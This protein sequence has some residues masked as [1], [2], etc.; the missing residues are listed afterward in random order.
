[1]TDDQARRSEHF[2]LASGMRALAYEHT[3][4]KEPY[5]VISHMFVSLPSSHA[6]DHFP[7]HQTL[8][9]FSSSCS[10]HHH[11]ISSSHC[12]SCHP[13]P[14]DV[15]PDVAPSSTSST[16]PT[17]D[18]SAPAALATAAAGPLRRSKTLLSFTTNNFFFHQH[19]T[20]KVLSRP[21]GT[22][23]TTYYQ[24]LQRL[25]VCIA[26]VIILRLTEILN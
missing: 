13:N 1:M 6:Y 8:C 12:R 26:I 11:S 14:A 23:S 24:S 17:R 15:P 4:D 16:F 3:D 19:S 5:H 7:T 9:F 22:A 20:S 2:K 21:C 18:L 10:L 25:A